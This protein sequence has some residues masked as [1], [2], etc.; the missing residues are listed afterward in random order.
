MASGWHNSPAT[1]C[2]ALVLAV[3]AAIAGGIWYTNSI[4]PGPQPAPGA[5][6]TKAAK[7]VA[8][9]GTRAD[10]EERWTGSLQC[11]ECHDEIWEK[12]Q[13]HPM[14]RASAPVLDAPVIEDYTEHTSFTKLESRTYRVER[15]AD[16]VLHHEVMTTADGEVLY[17]HAVEVHFEIGSGK[18][19]RT[20]LTNSGGVLTIS[21][22]AWYTQGS[23][24][25]LSPGYTPGNH[26]GFSRR[27][28][29]GCAECHVGRLAFD[30]DKPNRF[31][32]PVMLESQIGCE[33]CHG[34]GRD[35]VRWHRSNES[36][37]DDPIVNPARLESAA[38]EDVCN[39][40]HLQ[41]ERLPRYGK[42]MHDFRPGQRIEDVWTVFVK[43]AGVDKANA[44]RAVS[45]VDQMRDSLC[46]QKSGGR[47]G[48]TSCHDPHSVPT[49]AEKTEYFD[50]RCIS[51]HKEQGCSL[52]E[53]EQSAPPAAGSCVACHMPPLPANDVPHTSQTDHRV[54]R[55]ASSP[56]P[57]V[58][59]PGDLFDHAELR[60]PAIEVQRARALRRMPLVVQK[61][62]I[63]SAFRLA[64]QLRTVLE[65]FPDDV[66]TMQALAVFYMLR[67][68]PQEARQLWM[69]ALEL[70]PEN[71]TVLRQLAIYEA[72]QGDIRLAI[73]YL[74]RALIIDPTQVEH[75]ERLAKLLRSNNQL[76]EAVQTA[77]N[78]LELDPQS[79]P[80]RQWLAQTYR[81]SGR[82]PEANKQ[83][84]IIFRMQ[85]R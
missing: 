66:E 19:G 6:Q 39:Q 27:V 80:L 43:G 9:R 36:A 15:T 81:D 12:Y 35:H 3:S 68:R 85:G 61:Q 83:E 49:K 23:Q 59:E 56:P 30:P 16:R 53:A 21:P 4:V 62:D 22:I 78:G 1:W 20:Y 55:R 44:T 38:R 69:S 45:Q 41:G 5:S 31:Q 14:A 40:C 63:S 74:R 42:T 32:S 84:Q 28:V 60:L 26:Q 67:I 57:H 79:L 34:P 82:L 25:D 50:S 13:Q 24:W 64:E 72:S 70:Q 47:L 18:R 10:V 48:C 46:F 37:G 65:Q 54:V 11:K 7:P 17:D 29:D 52:P 8:R 76:D 77:L 51:C 58:A 73:G 75:H 2:V 33:R 71:E